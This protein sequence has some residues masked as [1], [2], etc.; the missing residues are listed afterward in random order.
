M[1]LTNNQREIIE[2]TAYRTANGFYCGDSE[3]MQKLIQ[4]RLM[5]SAGWKPFV[6]DEYFAL[7]KAGREYLRK[8]EN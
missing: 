7:T 1:K 4:L 6:P 8:M 2:H 3:D 5:K